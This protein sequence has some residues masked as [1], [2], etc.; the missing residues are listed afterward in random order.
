MLSIMYILRNFLNLAIVYVSVY[1]TTKHPAI[2]IKTF[3][4]VLLLVI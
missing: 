4:L 1:F 3:V 2:V